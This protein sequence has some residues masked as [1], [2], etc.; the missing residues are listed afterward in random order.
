MLKR[1]F[2]VMTAGMMLLA[3]CSNGGTPAANEA[4]P[5]AGGATPA[6]V[7]EEKQ[8]PIELMFWNSS[9]GGT[10]QGFMDTVGNAV[11]QKFPHITPKYI[12]TGKGTLMPDLIAAGTTPDIVMSS[13]P[14]IFSGYLA[15][16]MQYDMT[17][18]LNKY[19]LD[20]NQFEPTTIALI[21]QIS[22]GAMFGLPYG[23]NTT[24]LLYNRD[25]FDKFGVAYP[26]DGMTWDDIYELAKKMT[27]T[28]GGVHYRGFASSLEHLE[29]TNQLSFSLVDPKTKKSTYASDEKWRTF[30]DNLV[31]FYQ[32][33]GNGVDDKTVSQAAQLDA[34]QK[35]GTVAMYA[36][37]V[38]P[39]ESVT[40]NWDI[41]RLPEFSS[42]RGIG[43]QPYP[44]YMMIT[45]TSKHKD[46]AFKVIQY[47]TTDEEYLT[48]RA[49]RGAMSAVKNPKVIQAF[50][51]D[52]PHWQGRNIL[53]ARFPEK[54]AN[55]SVYT[56][57]NSVA[58][59]KYTANMNAFLTGKIPD[60]NTALRM[61]SEQADQAI[62][63]AMKK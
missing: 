22:N 1:S 62:A 7:P 48:S 12:P 60:T 55:P 63:D 21:K 38:V 49:K 53:K 35:E 8:E 30:V 23:S 61:M 16:G 4:N 59:T 50:G 11:K 20:L 2:T 29:M 45:G 33:P 46:N 57:F 51:H 31:R 34:F 3:A 41:V 40:V 15:N 17:E 47:L 36:G 44:S 26:T 5:L 42:A 43:S 19:K 39:A 56:E 13:L 52:L 37:I 10:E 58:L 28:E 14:G 27:R 24:H 54:L 32:I 6:P 18:Q 25:I 9:S